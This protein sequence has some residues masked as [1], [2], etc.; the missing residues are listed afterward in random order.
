MYKTFIEQ[1]CCGTFPLGSGLRQAAIRSLI[2]RFKII[3][4][5]LLAAVVH[6]AARST[7]QPMVS[8]SKENISLE[9]FFEEIRTQTGYNILYSAKK[10]DDAKRLS[11]SF[12]KLSLASALQLGLRN[13]PLTY[14][15]KRNTILIKEKPEDM[16]EVRARD[17]IS[18][19]EL[20]QG[21]TIRGTVVDAEGN[22]LADAT[23]RVAGSGRATSTDGLGR[24]V[25]SGVATGAMLQIT[26]V[27]F[28]AKTVKASGNAALFVQLEASS[29]LD[30]IVVIGY[31]VQRRADLTGAVASIKGGQLTAQAVSNPLQSLSG[32]SP[33]IEVLQNSGQPGNTV[34]VR[35]RGSNSLLGSNDPL[36]VIDGFPVLGSLETLNLNDIQSIDVLKDASA[37]AIYG[38]RGANGVVMVTTKRG[39]AGRQQVA[40]SGYYGMQAP[41][42]RID[43]LDAREFA[44]LAN[45]RAANDGENPYFDATEIANMGK[46]TDWQ[47]EIF[48]A[49]PMQ[50]HSLSLSGGSDRTA[51]SVSGNYLD[52][53][54]IIINSFYKQ[55]QLRSTLDHMLFDG[56]KLM[57][58]NMLSRIN[59]NT[60]RSDN[61]SRGNGVLSGALVAPPTL[62][63]Y[64][65][66]G[67]YTDI[68][69][70]A[71]SPDIAQN[72][73]LNARERMDMTT[74]SS[75]LSNA[76]LEGRLAP[77]L[78]LRSSVGVEYSNNRGDFYSPSLIHITA[79]GEGAIRY[80]ELT[81]IVN[82]NTLSY[83]RRFGGEHDLTVL[84][85]LASQQ[86]K[87]QG[88][89]A[90]ATG[91]Q[92]DLLGNLNLQSASSP[93]TPESFRS[94]YAILSGLGR[95]NYAFGNK[96]LVTASIRADGSSRFGKAN[97]WGYFPSAAIAWRVSE[98]PFW[99]EWSH[100]ANELK[101]RASWGKT[102]NTSVAPY[103]SLAI[104][105]AVSTVFDQN[106]TTGFAPG[107]N[108]ANPGLKWETT[109]Q[110]DVG[111]DLGL[112]RN[113]VSLT[114]DYYY[115][116]TV[117]LL[118]STPVALSSGY[119]TMS[120]N[121]GS[122][123][124]RGVDASISAVVVEGP[125]RWDLAVNLSV[126]RNKV[127][128]LADETDIFGTTIGLPISL[129]VNLVR[130]GHPV[131][132]FYG[133]REDGLTDAGDI[134]FIDQDGNHVIN[135]LDRTIIGDP[136]PDY[137]LGISS[138]ASYKNFTLSL[139]VNSVQGNDIF[140]FNA[141][142][143][144]DGFSFGINQ[145]R[146]V[147]GNYWTPENPNPNAKYPRISKN[148]RYLV[149]DRFVEDGSYIRLRNVQLAYTFSGLGVGK[150]D[151]S[152]SQVYI[153]AQNLLTITNYSF[154]SPEVNTIGA[155][156]SRGVDQFGYPDARTV[157][158]GM[159]LK[160]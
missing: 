116:K 76:I 136:N 86:T 147:L 119:T 148:T 43:M 79:T 16:Q 81:N 95:I 141:S 11:V 128:A 155:G 131:G 75:L 34:S 151:F 48:E 111:I 117:D 1:L 50:N 61:S 140:N 127:L 103:Q 88:V 115:K 54:G 110:V 96:Y 51:F 120:R 71:F 45:V 47:E 93:G 133:Y 159:R 33:G 30:E 85:G 102:G 109:N 80:T 63:V 99:S 145:I 28:Q 31:G 129:P 27:G 4:I 36:Y 49:T 158:L 112:W 20:V 154:Y 97:K 58:N 149:S 91:F 3:C 98:E 72:P 15:I 70:Y 19:R 138:T 113:R 17:G 107:A 105:G 150:L 56:W 108:Q 10:I 89:L 82:E 106:L 6:V 73:V 69:A 77:Y 123:E 62:G 26:Y 90:K 135:T 126:N 94:K 130:V 46:G 24:F 160:F 12:N 124:N 125:F 42:K 40:Y 78:T 121:V 122:V 2:M 156:I 39:Q 29:D 57:L 84:G 41:Y 83:H 87:E 74:K 146:D 134:N 100:I 37:T 8:I 67:S 68:R 92:T 118:N 22:P 9:Q 114:L 157:M 143:I 142:N 32:V 13:F 101:I 153:A 35:V 7:A 25:L 14:S 52:Q 132:V 60:L 59:T 137:I 144:A 38:S 18:N 64:N 53:R 44:T 5:L 21:D 66:D 55:S 23:V 65:P 139:L 152:G 104:L